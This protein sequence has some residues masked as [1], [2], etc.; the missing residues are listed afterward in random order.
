MVC[1]HCDATVA[2][3]SGYVSWC[4]RCGWN[5][6]PP[7]RHVTTDGPLDRIRRVMGRRLG[8]RLISSEELEP[9]ARPAR[10][11]AYAIAGCAHVLTALLAAAAVVLLAVSFPDPFGIAGAVLLV[12][13]ALLMRPRVGRIPHGWPLSRDDSPTLF[14]LVEMVAAALPTRPPDVVQLDSSYNASFA[15]FGLRRRSALTL[16]L[17]L[18]AVA[19]PQERVALVAHE[20]AHDRNRDVSRGFFVGS[21]LDALA[22]LYAVLSPGRA[23][24]ELSESALV[25]VTPLV[26]A[27][28][29]VVSLPFA[30]LLR[31]EYHLL[32]HDF[33]RAEYRADALAAGVAGT[34]PVVS[35]HEMF[36]LDFLVDEAAHRSV[37][38][39]EPRDFFSELSALVESIPE[40]ERERRRRVARLEPARLDTTHPPTAARIKVLEERAQRPAAVQLPDD[41]SRRLDAELAPQKTSMGAA[42]VSAY[43][44]SLYE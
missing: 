27:I 14:A 25:V 10:V 24:S 2:V 21:A 28:L 3:D 43:R 5:L 6:E 12:S 39:T 7:A 33:R 15:R 37:H 4:D 35:L 31:L 23:A 18:F 11:A 20:L 30:V 41:E 1:P 26:W 36:L 13:L 19:E 16:G 22:E 44:D 40:R 34:A 32:L 38:A 8:G 9:R 17:P 42:I 29:W